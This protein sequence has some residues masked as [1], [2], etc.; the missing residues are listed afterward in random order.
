MPHKKKTSSNISDD[1]DDDE[2]LRLADATELEHISTPIS[3][4]AI[5]VEVNPATELFYLRYYFF[6]VSAIVIL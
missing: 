4:T 5:V 1:F 3:S 2:L 6:M